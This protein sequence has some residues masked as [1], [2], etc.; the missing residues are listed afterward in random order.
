MAGQ[1]GTHGSTAG[2]ALGRS[3]SCSSQSAFRP[4]RQDAPL[5][6]VVTVDTNRF[7]RSAQRYVAGRDPQEFGHFTRAAIWDAGDV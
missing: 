6:R 2:S 5:S 7:L 3:F 1:R 4:V